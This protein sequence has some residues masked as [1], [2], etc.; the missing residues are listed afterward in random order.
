VVSGLP[1]GIAQAVENVPF[2]E[3][4]VDTAMQVECP[5]EAFGGCLVIPGRFLDGAEVIEGVGLPVMVAEFKVHAKR[6][7]EISSRGQQVPDPLLHS[8]ELIRAGLASANV[9]ATV[10]SAVAESLQQ[11]LHPC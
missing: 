2:S 5:G 8:A 6:L 9:P 10:A 1:L 4:V 3:A 7:G 11:R